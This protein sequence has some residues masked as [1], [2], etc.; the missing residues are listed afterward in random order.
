[1]A[2]AGAGAG[3][4]DFECPTA[5]LEIYVNGAKSEVQGDENNE[6]KAT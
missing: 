5:L 1:M 4:L 6:V 2:T 3:Y